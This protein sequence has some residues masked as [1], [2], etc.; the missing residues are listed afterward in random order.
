[1]R[2]S[3]SVLLWT[4]SADNGTYEVLWA[5]FDKLFVGVL[6]HPPKPCYTV[7]SLLDYLESAVDEILRDC[8]DADIVLAGDFNRLPEDLVVLRTGLTQIVHQPTRGASVLD[9]IYESCP[10]YTTVRVVTSVLKTDH[11]A[12]VAYSTTTHFVPFKTRT[13]KTFRRRSPAQNASFLH[14]M[15]NPNVTDSTQTSRDTH[16]QFQQFYYNALY[17]LNYFYPER[18]ITL[19]SRDPEFVTPAIKA[20]LRRKNRLMRA[21]LC[22]VDGKINSKGM[23]AAVRELTGRTQ[24]NKTVDG[25]TATSLNQHYAAISTDASYTPPSLK[26]TTSLHHSELLSEWEVFRLL[27]TLRPTSTGLDQ[28]PAWFLKIAAPLF[29]KPLANLF[30][31]SIATSTAPAQWKAAYIRPASKVS[32]PH[33]HA[34]FRPISI[35]PV[36]SR[37]LEKNSCKTFSLPVLYLPTTHLKFQ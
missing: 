26:Q 27:D 20:S 34:D 18:S 15:A 9:H 19:S 24:Q 11:K 6:Y 13:K 10:I 30:N 33:S 12:V 5:K 37:I 32:S 8:P 1:V 28:I 16:E 2:S 14:H 35:T 31:L 23:W 21:R 36:L 7:E 17:L 3:L 25:V 22:K 29:C 4:F